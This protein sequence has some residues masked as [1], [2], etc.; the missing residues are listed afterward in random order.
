MTMLESRPVGNLE[1]YF[2]EHSKNGL[3]YNVVVGRRLQLN[4]PLPNN[5]E[6]G[7]SPKSTLSSLPQSSEQ[8]LALLAPA[9]HSVLPRHPSMQM[10]VVRHTTSKPC[11]Q[12]MTCIDLAKVVRVHTIGQPQQIAS[13][14]EKE[15]NTPYDLADSTV[16]LWRMFVVR[17][18]NDEDKNA[19]YLLYSFHHAIA[20]GRSATNLV[21]E[22]VH[23]LNQVVS[24]KEWSSS[25][26]SNI[27]QCPNK[28]LPVPFEDRVKSRLDMK[29]LAT[30]FHLVITPAFIKKRIEHKYWAGDI[31]ASSRNTNE[32]QLSYVLLT[33]DETKQLCAAAKRE[34]TT[35]NSVLFAA[36]MFAIKVIF[37]SKEDDAPKSRFR[38][39]TIVCPRSRLETPTKVD[40]QFP[41]V[42]DLWTTNH[43]VEPT[44]SFW[45]FTREYHA[46]VQKR[47]LTPKGFQH[48]VEIF[49]LMRFYLKPPALYRKMLY[50]WYYRQQHGRESTIR[51]SNLGRMNDPWMQGHDQVAAPAFKEL[52]SL[53]SQSAITV[54]ATF[55]IGAV[56]ANESLF[57]S[58]A[59]QRSAFDSRD[60]PDR[61]LSEVK[62]ILFEAIA[63]GQT[64]Y[65]LRDALSS[66]L[67]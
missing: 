31:P 34:N 57:L 15:H 9:L 19:F 40:E 43:G 2:L 18:E 11:F 25:S 32:T 4:P 28:P 47:A 22:L 53:F 52:H 46:T 39:S 50:N 45:A 26:T 20:D 62:R 21:T 8:W 44:T 35:V 7:T 59:W 58:N 60:K 41:C 6:N 33:K 56:T 13:F 3:Y 61:V 1:R 16:P 55:T 29:A 24:S 36:I 5:N 49:R 65:Q 30:A 66:S 27:Y 42:L 51:L 67:I 54:G 23:E 12:T 14:I 38:G 17:A 37:L 63:P 48:L 10:A 64:G